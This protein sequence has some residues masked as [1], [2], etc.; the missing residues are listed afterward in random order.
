[1]KK[2]QTEEKKAI[3][4]ASRV[5]QA[6]TWHML[7]KHI[8]LAKVDENYPKFYRLI[9]A[10]IDALFKKER[11]EVEAYIDSMEIKEKYEAY[12]MVERKII[13]VLDNGD[14]LR[15]WYVPGKDPNDAEYEDSVDEFVVGDE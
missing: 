12:C 10:L 11:E 6:K 4:W 7:L 9:D 13:D 8:S 2:K 15:H 5:S 14:F 3:H 1:M